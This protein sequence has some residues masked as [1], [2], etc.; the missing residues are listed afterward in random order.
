MNERTSDGVAT[1]LLIEDSPA[2]V[3][4]VRESLAECGRPDSLNVIGDGEEALAFLR[5]EGQYADAPRPG[6]ILLD[7]N[8][9]KKGGREVLAEIKADPHLGRIPV[10]ILTTS[11]AERDIIACYDLHA[12]GYIV[13][14]FDLA[15][16]FAMMQSLVT[17]WID[18]AELPRIERANR[19][20]NA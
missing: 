5:R 16:F 2:C 11:D 15:A 17:F 1:I 4:L 8:L 10:L 7:L 19:V 12:N 6:L 13:K 14:P 9:P 3:E 18:T 20:G